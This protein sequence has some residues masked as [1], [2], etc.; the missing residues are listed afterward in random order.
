MESLVNLLSFYK[1]KRV[2]VTGHTGFKG[3]WLCQILIMSGANVAG[4]SLEPPTNPNL[5][6]LLS[7]DK[8]MVSEIGDIRD[9][10]HLQRFFNDFQP[11]IVFHLAAQPIVRESYKN[12]VFTYQTNVLGTVNVCECVRTHHSV[13]SFLNITTD[14]VY[15]NV[16]ALNHSFTE[17]EKLDGFDPY[18]NSKSCSDIITH[19][20][21][22]SFFKDLGISV[23][24]ARAGNVIGGGDFSSD[25]IIPDCLRSLE[26]GS[27][28]IIRNPDS[29]RPYQHV[30]E[31]LACYLEIA[32]RQSEERAL[33]GS[34]N[35]GP[36]SSDCITTMK[37]VSLF[38][39][40][41]NGKFR[42]EIRPDGGPHEAS[43]LRLDNSKMKNVFGWKPKTNI[44]TA[45]RLTSDWIK[46]FLSHKSIVPISEKQ[47]A[48][49]F[50]I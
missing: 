44:E 5:F 34:F 49:F 45:V 18:S 47:I 40:N 33:C 24:T 35:I 19:S 29:I 28:L 50:S 16:D 12:P 3:A 1:G 21:Y 41:F 37:L 14:K 10:P 38:G 20:Y 42:S 11:E 6:S 4:Y 25:R 48:E 7:L 13:I 43:Y 39:E 46:I 31:P 23:S 8:K 27:P 22:R 36:D 2:L 30:F 15:E 32:K 9:L 26:N 17:D